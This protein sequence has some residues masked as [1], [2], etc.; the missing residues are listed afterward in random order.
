[1]REV[2]HRQVQEGAAGDVEGWEAIREVAL[3]AAMCPPMESA[4]VDLHQ[5]I[6]VEEGRQ[7][8]Y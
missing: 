4:R 3:E 6:M 1:V 8:A 5:A 2:E 7:R